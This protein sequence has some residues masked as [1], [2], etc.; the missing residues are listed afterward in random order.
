MSKPSIFCSM[1]SFKFFNCLSNKYDLHERIQTV[2]D[3][4][5]IIMYKLSY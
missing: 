2:E 5:P 4:Y 3:A 1:K